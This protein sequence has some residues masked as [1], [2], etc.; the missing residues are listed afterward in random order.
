M[1]KKIFSQFFPKP[2]SRALLLFTLLFISAAGPGLRQV[3]A[4]CS[5]VS[6]TEC[7]ALFDLYESMGGQTWDDGILGWKPEIPVVNWTGVTVRN[8]HVVQLD[9]SYKRL[10][11]VIPPAIGDLPYLEWLDFTGNSLTGEIPEEIANLTQLQYLSFWDNRLWGGIPAGL[12][13]IN[14]LW[15]LDLSSNYLSGTIPENIENLTNLEY[16]WLEENLLTGEIPGSVANLHN[17]LVLSVYTN[18]LEGTMPS[19]IDNL[20]N[21]LEFYA[22]GNFLSG[23]IPA[24][25]G[26]LDNLT[27]FVVGNNR[28]TGSIPVS[29]TSLSKLQNLSLGNNLL[30]G[31]IPESISNLSNLAVLD[32]SKNLFTGSIPD[33]LGTMASLDSIN[34]NG[35]RLTGPIPA[36][37]GNLFFLQKLFLDNNQLTGTIPP[38]L[39]NLQYLVYL[40]L[41]NNELEGTIPSSLGNMTSLKA[42][43][44][45]NNNLTG[46]IPVN[47]GYMDS[48]QRLGLSNNK[49]EGT[50][51]ESLGYAQYLRGLWA[52]GNL[53]AGELPSFMSS[54][55]ESIDLR[56]N[57]L[58]SGNASVLNQVEA[59]HGNKFANTQTLRPKN[60]SARAA[61]NTG[62]ENRIDLTWDPIAYTGNDGGYEI[63][64]KKAGDGD[65]TGVGFTADKSIDSYT[66][67]DLE[68]DADYRFKVRAITWEHQGNSNISYSPVAETAQVTTGNISRAFIPV[69]KRGADKFTGIVV[70]N[71]GDTP[72]NV[73]LSAYDKS[74]NLEQATSNPSYHQVPAHEQLSLIGTEFFGSVASSLISWI[75]V[76]AE[77]TNQMGS[78]F[79]FGV[80]DTSRLDGAETQT[81]YAKK[82]FFTRPLAEGLLEGFQPDIQFSVVNP[83]D[84]SLD[85]NF[86]LTGTTGTLASGPITIPAKG[87]IARTPEELFGSGH[88]L[89]NA[90]MSVETSD[91]PGILGFARI[92]IPGISTALGLNAAE[93]S[94]ERFLYSAQMASGDDI[95]T[96][97]RLVNTSAET[98]QIRL[99]AI[100]P[101][102]S[103]IAQD[104]QIELCSMCVMEQNFSQ[105][106]ALPDESITVGSLE[107]ETDGGGLIGDVIF[108]DG[109]NLKYA[110]AMPLQTRLFKEAVFNHVANLPVLFTGI[111]LFNPGEE[112]AS[113]D[114]T[115]Y[116]TEANQGE[117]VAVKNIQLGPGQRLSRTLTDADM[118]PALEPQSGGYIKIQSSRPIVGQ[119]LFGDVDLRYMAAI[120]PTTRVEP[121]FN[122]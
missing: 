14:S 90:F 102:G 62:N 57:Q 48:L 26:N 108:A 69:W 28:L 22:A 49:L 110:L 19:K 104:S 41:H 72:F 84:E 87:F 63:S 76:A 37:L 103:A 34:L 107:I 10:S 77:N 9:L 3:S 88:G 54:R 96:S 46:E 70:S 93:A 53:M 81:R 89:E 12:T 35:N 114:I 47:L 2:A 23:P 64:L 50:I 61:G 78:L 32:L 55:P 113:I 118:W 91:G 101:D 79:L 60:L 38:Q 92:E 1:T 99:S 100:A 31:E 80:S 119:Q 71:F 29:L 21:L 58:Q 51:P 116:G 59:K 7:T 18:Q 105:L 13:G 16:L 56:W 11:N 86:V 15:Y 83:F 67:P 36:N 111:A 20:S 65:Y 97:V 117:V 82:L 109:D 8:G 5:G 44:L 122:N 45:T 42:L 85:V 98:R 6:S 74:G 30:T 120:P 112:T 68:P 106:F 33:S 95:V 27:Q 75:E 94:P 43:Y 39:G 66:I 40:M 115:V 24:G 121:M 25:V 52:S 4:Q 17:L 73:T